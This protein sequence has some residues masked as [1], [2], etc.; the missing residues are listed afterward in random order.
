MK[1]IWDLGLDLFRIT[2]L[3]HP[4]VLQRILV[5]LLHAV[6]CDRRELPVERDAM[7]RVVCMLTSLTLYNSHFEGPF[8]QV[9][10]P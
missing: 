5:A 8:I 4:S 3:E 9:L 10:N 2:I 6:E 7:C 1:P